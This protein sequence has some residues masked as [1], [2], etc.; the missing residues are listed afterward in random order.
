MAY[1]L[2]INAVHL[3]KKRTRKNCTDRS[4]WKLIVVLFSSSRSVVTKTDVSS[5]GIRLRQSNSDSNT[6]TPTVRSILSFIDDIV[7][8]STFEKTRTYPSH[9]WCVIS[10]RWLGPVWALSIGSF[11]LGE[12][13]RMSYLGPR[14]YVYDSFY[15]HCTSNTLTVKW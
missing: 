11:E 9:R 7:R 3:W 10:F 15:D 1:Y 8:E 14:T 2:T 12:G 4:I 5:V 6:P 13:Y